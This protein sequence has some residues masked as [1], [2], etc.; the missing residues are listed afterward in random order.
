MGTKYEYSEG[1]TY[2]SESTPITI[3]KIPTGK[4]K[5]KTVSGNRKGWTTFTASPGTQGLTVEI[6]DPYYSIIYDK[7]L[8]SDPEGCLTYAK[9][10]K[11]FT[12]M[13][14]GSGN[15]DEGSWAEG[16]GT[17]LDSIK[18]GYLD[19]D[20]TFVES[21]KSSVTGSSA[22]NS[23]CFTRIPKIYQKVTD[24][25]DAGDNSKV[26]LDLSLEPF[27]GAT[28]HPAFIMDE[29][30]LTYKDIGRYLAYNDSSVLRSKS[31][32]NPTNYI[33]RTDARKYAKNNG[34]SNYGI[35][36]YY[37]WDLINKLFLLVFKSWNSQDALGLGY[38]GL[39]KSTADYT[40]RTNGK[41]WMYGTSSSTSTKDHIS[42]LGLEDWWGNYTQWIDN[43]LGD[44]S[45]LYAS[46]TASPS[47]NV[48]DMTPICVTPHYSSVIY[49]LTC[50][51]H[52]NNFFIGETEGGTDSS[53]MCDTQ[54]SIP[55]S[56]TTIYS[57]HGGGNTTDGS[58]A[59]AFNFQAYNRIS[60]EHPNIGVRLVHWE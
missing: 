25:S 49:P 13:R 16:N 7:S 8:A 5:I 24:V 6:T 23:N 30:E 15:A 4:Y 38:T 34:N 1:A 54:S 40:G 55:S 14:G 27:S 22:A 50:Q 51:A 42:F 45:Y 58:R 56:G 60:G 41:S 33:S 29:I 53:G 39:S 18:V 52:L 12:P 43:I 47:D 57:F 37:D 36:S 19:A 46:N 11:R 10:C 48:S 31:G 20:E 17:L 28:L 3:G 2:Q 32:V 59:G 9:L 44:V 35:L 21:S 26:Q